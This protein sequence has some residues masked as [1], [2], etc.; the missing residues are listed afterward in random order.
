RQ[1]APSMA[2]TARPRKPLGLKD[3]QTARA[4]SA[5]AVRVH[6]QAR[7]LDGHLGDGG[8]GDGFILLTDGIA[9]NEEARAPL[10]CLALRARHSFV[11]AS[12]RFK[13]K[14][15][16]VMYAASSAAGPSRGYSPI[17]TSFSAAA[18]SASNRSS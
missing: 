2:L 12:S 11:T 8:Q 13:I 15:A 17:R 16:P 14:L 5:P 6:S 4:P 1:P 9:V 7:G 3:L 10:Y 18:G